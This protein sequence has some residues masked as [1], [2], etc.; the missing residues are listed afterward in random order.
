MKIGEFARRAGVSTSKVRYY[1]ARGLLLAAARTESGYRNYGP[2]DLERLVR[3]KRAQALGFTLDQIARFM[4]LT[5]TERKAKTG[6]IEAAEARLAQLDL[7]L[8]EIQAQRRQIAAFLADVRADLART[9][10]GS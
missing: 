3:V 10:G 1:E 8:A 6:V 7:H 5:E 9:G 4:S 2:A